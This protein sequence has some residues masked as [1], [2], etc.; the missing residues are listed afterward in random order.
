MTTL[1]CV[2]KKRTGFTLVEMLVTLALLAVVASIT[3]V[4]CLKARSRS[5][6]LL[7][8]DHQRQISTALVAHYQDHRRFPADGAEANLAVSLKDYIS[9]PLQNRQVALPGVYRCPNDRGNALSNSYEPFYVRRRQ[10]ESSDFFVLGCPRHADA[11]AAYLNMLG[12]RGGVRGA[13]GTIRVNGGA[14]SPEACATERTIASGTIAFED[15][16]HVEVTRTSSAYEV[17]AIASFRQEDGRLYTIVRVNG[18][19][20][21]DFKVTPGSKFEVVTPVAIIGVR[22]TQFRVATETGYARISVS[23]GTVHVWDKVAEKTYLLEAGDQAEIGNATWKRLILK[24]DPDRLGYW[25]VRNEDE[26]E[27]AF[28]VFERDIL[29]SPDDWYWTGERSVAPGETVSLYHPTAAAIKIV[30]TLPD[31]TTVT[32]ISERPDLLDSN[33]AVSGPFFDGNKV[34]YSLTNNNEVAVYVSSLNYTWCYDAGSLK[35]VKLQ[36]KKIYEGPVSPS[37]LSIESGWYGSESDRKIAVGDTRTL[38]FEHEALA[39]VNPTFYSMHLHV[40]DGGN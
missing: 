11:D 39:P 37:T 18:S 24:P 29:T 40:S 28:D 36:A 34:T 1:R 9:W 5:R 4:I 23:S 8:L 12:M 2:F 25:T 35:H 6:A 13:E 26:K 31:G 21:A 30:Y 15:G 27:I 38:L 20:E 32:E 16:S 33:M 17:A 10:L 14:I 7:C 3:G 19:G 22:G